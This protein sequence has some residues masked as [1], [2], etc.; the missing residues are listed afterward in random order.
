MINI[1]GVVHEKEKLTWNSLVYS[2]IVLVLY[3]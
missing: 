1:Y 2:N 3:I